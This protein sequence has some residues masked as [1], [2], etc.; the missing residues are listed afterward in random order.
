VFETFELTFVCAVSWLF[1]PLHSQFAL[2]FQVLAVGGWQAQ[3]DGRAGH[4]S[5]NH[6]EQRARHNV[7]G[8]AEL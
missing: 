1:Q 8:V 6:V 7:R 5:P 3:L 2:K 4:Q